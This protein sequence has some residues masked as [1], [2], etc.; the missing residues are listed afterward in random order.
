[1]KG[2]LVVIFA[3][4]S[5]GAAEAQFNRPSPQFQAM[6]DL[7]AALRAKDVAKAMTFVADDVVVFPP[8]GEVISGRTQVE[9]AL[10]DFVA[11]NAMELKFGSLGS[12]AAAD[13]GYDSGVFEWALRPA[14]ADKKT[15]GQG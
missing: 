10:K 1:M 9:A 4:A 5:A 2:L 12:S 6:M 13:L 7:V 11:K 8:R 3:L 15:E 14:G